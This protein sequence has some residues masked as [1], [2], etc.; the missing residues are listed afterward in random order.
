MRCRRCTVFSRPNRSCRA[1]TCARLPM[2][3]AAA[4]APA[5]HRLQRAHA[6][7]PRSPRFEAAVRA[8][9]P[10][11]FRVFDRPEQPAGA[12]ADEEM[13]AIRYIEPQARNAAAL[14]VNALSIG[15]AAEAIRRAQ[16]S[17]QPSATAG[18]RLTQEAADQIGVVVYQ[19]LPGTAS[20]PGRGVVFVTLR[21]DDALGARLQ[22]SASGLRWCLVDRDPG[23]AQ[24]RLA[25]PAGC[26]GA[27]EAATCA[28]PRAELC[29][30]RMGAA[31]RCPTRPDWPKRSM[32]TPGCSRCSGW[33]RRRCWARCC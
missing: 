3:A 28:R 14:G 23:S 2:V 26:D 5:G 25:G 27:V 17:A 16:R 8:D 10:A 18:F 24:R 12:S 11:D 29:R 15:A 6:R 13:V 30:A 4:A 32:P 31:L 33:R 22:H 19:A 1:Q 20:A 9:G 21:M 7:V